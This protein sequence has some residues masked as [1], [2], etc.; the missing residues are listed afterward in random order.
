MA[1]ILNDLES[2]T[3][4]LNN[5]AIESFGTGD[6]ITL[7][8]VNPHTS[9]INSSDGGVTINKRVDSDVYDLTV[10]LQKNSEDDSF[11]NSAMNTSN[12]TV[13]SGTLKQDITR[14]GSDAQVSWNLN[15]GS[16]ITQ[17]TYITNDTDGNATV[18]YVIRFRN[19][20]RAL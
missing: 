19:A 20:S 1:V 15:N 16:I 6:I 8:P 12:L 3:L 17:P 11:L 2:V 7:T 9:Q 18:E 4:L 5:R 10:V 13:L 14:D